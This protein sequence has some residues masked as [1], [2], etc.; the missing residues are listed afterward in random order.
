M[1]GLVELAGVLERRLSGDLPGFRAHRRMA[2]SDRIRGMYPSAPN[3]ETSRGAVLIL[4]YPMAGRI[5]T[6][7]IQR[8]EYPGVHSNQISFPGGKSEFSDKHIQDTAIR[9]AEEEI[10]VSGNEI[11]IC[12]LLSPLFIPV[13]NIEV[14]PVVGL[15]FSKPVFTPDPDEVCFIIEAG[16]DELANPAIIKQ[17]NIEISGKVITIPYYQVK[18]FHIWGATAMIISEFLE[19]YTSL[20]V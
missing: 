3:G 16:I 8:S 15:L 13:S 5:H 12:G 4:L 1:M 6:V 11:R 19:L 7:L 20:N 9:E 10:G 2:P 14:T 17:K 18:D